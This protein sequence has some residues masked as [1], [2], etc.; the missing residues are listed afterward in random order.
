ML[1]GNELEFVYSSSKQNT[2]KSPRIHVLQHVP[3][4]NPG[5]LSDWFEQHNCTV[6]YNR[7][8][9][10]GAQLPDLNLF[11]RLVIM[12]GPMDVCETEKY[13]WLEAEKNFI[14]E[15]IV[16]GKSAVGICLGSQLIAAA[17]GAAVY[18]NKKP[19]IG[20]FPVYKTAVSANDP[21]LNDFNTETMVFHWHGDTFDLP[22][23]AQ[24]LFYSEACRNQGFRIGRQVLGLQ[25]HPEV[26]PKS[27]KEM[28]NHVGNEL[29]PA[30]YIQSAGEILGQQ[31]H[32][33]ANNQRMF[34]LMNL[35]D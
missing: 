16:Q 26:T 1:S 34:A 13:A 14:R 7:F 30:Q 32:I 31:E 15:A 22:P 33:A 2:M 25:F 3:F 5:C 9:E 10:E 4:E 29:V 18:P 21:F 28:I 8:Y 27:L 12:G 19:E 23:H 11:D 17:L 6:S 20:W 35:L 24:H